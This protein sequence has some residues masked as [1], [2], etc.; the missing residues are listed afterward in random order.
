VTS[1][2]LP[3][4]PG[5]RSTTAVASAALPSPSET[6]SRTANPTTQEQRRD[7]RSV[8]RTQPLAR[9]APPVSAPAGQSPS[10]SPVITQAAPVAPINRPTTAPVSREVAALPVPDQP[11]A[12]ATVTQ[13][14]VKPTS[15]YIQAGAFANYDNA[16]RLSSKLSR[17]GASQV[18][19]VSVGGQQ[20][21]RVRVGPVSTVQEADTILEGVTNDA[22]QARIVAD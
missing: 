11:A 17:F 8:T 9:P 16:M 18:S 21:F 12:R 1:D 14:A 22:P 6:V 7:G 2:S 20:F 10:G 4:P 15:L 19:Q 5:S 3:P 13:Q